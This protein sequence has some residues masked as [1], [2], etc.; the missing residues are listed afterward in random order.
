MA[1][2]I[3]RERGH[4]RLQ[5]LGHSLILRVSEGRRE[6]PAQ[7]HIDQAG[8]SSEGGVETCGSGTVREGVRYLLSGPDREKT[9]G[10][11]DYALMLMMLKL[12]F[13]CL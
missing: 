4:G 6:R 7:F 2:L 9:E 13:I 1:A 8:F 3:C 10:T 12:S 11:R 5:A